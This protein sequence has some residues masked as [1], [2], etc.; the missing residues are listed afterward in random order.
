MIISPLDVLTNKG[1][2]LLLYVW[3]VLPHIFN[4]I[5][6]QRGL[7]FNDWHFQILD[8]LRNVGSEMG[9][10]LVRLWDFKKNILVQ[11]QHILRE[12]GFRFELP[13]FHES[14]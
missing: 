3:V 11:L 5:D 13:K 1:A 4:I 10:Q 2:V 8:R 7:S 14:A 9:L 12:M 6:N